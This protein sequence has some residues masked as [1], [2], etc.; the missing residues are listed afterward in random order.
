MSPVLSRMDGMI[1][2]VA[3]PDA[4][5][6]HVGPLHTHR[7]GK[8]GIEIDIPQDPL[9]AQDA[10]DAHAYP[11][12]AV[13]V[14]N[15]F[16]HVASPGHDL[17]QVAKPVLSCPASHVGWIQRLFE[18]EDE[19]TIAKPGK[20]VI[21][22]ENALFDAPDT[23]NPVYDYGIEES[24][25]LPPAPMAT[26]PL[27][28][29]GEGLFPGLP[30]IPAPCEPAPGSFELPSIGSERHY[31]G[32]C[33]PCAFLHSR[34]CQNGAMCSFCHLCDRGEKKRRQKAKKAS[35]KGGA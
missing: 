33:R 18:D 3:A 35:F 9:D 29:Q 23:R 5:H 28:P 12:E 16:I 13:Q 1:H 2:G 27:V 19:P 22:L 14:R 17:Q 8:Y 34:G 20:P 21:C 30:S 31:S 10:A 25:G 4:L 6:P 7:V 15:T 32:D 24:W 26:A 11:P